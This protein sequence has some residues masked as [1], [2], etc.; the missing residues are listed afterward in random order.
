MEELFG[1]CLIKFDKEA[2]QE[3]SKQKQDDEAE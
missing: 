3:E 1:D 2:A